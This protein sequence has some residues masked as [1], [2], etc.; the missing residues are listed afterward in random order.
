MIAEI[1]EAIDAGSATTARTFEYTEAQEAGR[2]L[3]DAEVTIVL[4]TGCSLSVSVLPRS[5]SSNATTSC[6][7]PQVKMDAHVK[8]LFTTA[9]MFKLKKPAT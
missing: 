2:I 6:V 4:W 9:C 7:L 8:W 1:N 5:L 3:T